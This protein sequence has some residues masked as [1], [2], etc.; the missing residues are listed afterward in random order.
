LGE[1]S[2]PEYQVLVR[3]GFDLNDDV[4]LWLALRSIGEVPAY[5]GG[6]DAGSVP[7]YTELD[8]TL[9]WTLRPAL[10]WAVTGR[11]LLH[12]SHPEIGE[13]PTNRREIQRSIQT[14]LRWQF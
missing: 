7:A 5:E 10:E 6:V 11:N 14:T 8:A 13:S 1:A 9:R 3:S 4:H 2:N 12:S